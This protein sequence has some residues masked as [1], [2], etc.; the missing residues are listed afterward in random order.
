MRFNKKAVFVEQVIALVVVNIS[1]YVFRKCFLW[2]ATAL[3]ASV[4]GRD[5][6]VLCNQGRVA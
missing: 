3:N 2:G 4:C 5:N 1:G 6:N